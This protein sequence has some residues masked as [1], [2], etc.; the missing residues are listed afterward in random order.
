MFG[1]YFISWAMLRTRFRVSS[2]TRGL[3]LKT[4]ETVAIE[5]PAL[6][7]TSLIVLF[8]GFSL[9]ND[10]GLEDLNV[11]L[12]IEINESL[13]NMQILHEIGWFFNVSAYNIIKKYPFVK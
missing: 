10:L 1:V 2:L 11:S 6:C 5:T 9:R 13:R 12:Y 7:A 3:L 8:T 4:R